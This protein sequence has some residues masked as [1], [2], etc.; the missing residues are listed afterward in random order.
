MQFIVM[1]CQLLIVMVF[2]AAAVG[3]I[4]RRQSFRD[5]SASVERLVPRRLATP[6]ASLVVTL[7][8]AVIVLTLT[9]ARVVGLLLAAIVLIGF[10]AVAEFAVRTGRVVACNCFGAVSDSVLGRV[11][12]IRNI[13]LAAVAATGLAVAA[14]AVPRVD[15]EI[16][17]IAT[18]AAFMVA[19]LLVRW[20][21]IRSLFAKS[22]F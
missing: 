2:T 1:F 22:S 18:L 6:I 8:F 4:R 15:A 19:V 10:A 16:V 13:G 9:P 14:L 12:V 20:E 17:P 21:D 7:E 11:H 5:F 3:K